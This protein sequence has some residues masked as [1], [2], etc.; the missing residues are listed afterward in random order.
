MTWQASYLC[1]RKNEWMQCAS[2]IRIPLGIE[3][4]IIEMVEMGR[5][6][7]NEEKLDYI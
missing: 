4:S 6:R 5:E 1:E 2:T 3:P 7:E